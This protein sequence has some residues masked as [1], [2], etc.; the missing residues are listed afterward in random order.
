M[1]GENSSKNK[2]KFI[3]RHIMVKGRYVDDIL[4]GKKRA[5]IRLGIY[6]VKYDELIVHGAGKPIAKIKVERI[7]YKKIKEL[8][9]EDARKDGFNNVKE[10]LEELRKT[11][12]EFSPNDYVTII[13]FRLTKDLSNIEP[14]HPY[15]GLEP[16][17][18]ARLGLRYLGDELS[19][20]EKKI[21]ISMTRTKS[22]RLTAIKLYGSLTKRWIVRKT[23]KK[24]LRKLIEKG[25]IPARERDHLS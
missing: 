15:L 18:V 13:E 8:D 12:G 14:E 11:Y 6:K 1:S 3:G 5:T 24:V 21:L 25:V 19:N 20:E 16:A 2:V 23:L 7:R 17:D 22:I 10:L 4:K 9:D